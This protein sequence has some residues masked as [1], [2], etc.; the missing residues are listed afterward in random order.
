MAVTEAVAKNTGNVATL[1]DRAKILIM[2]SVVLGLFLEA[3]DQTIVAT[4]LPAIV[5][6]FQGID[7]LAWVSTGYL[8][9]S[10]ALVPIYGKLSDVLGRR[11]IILFG[12]G[13]FLLGSILCGVA[14]SMLQLVIFRC[15]QGAGAAA[16]TSTAF[17]IPADLYPPSERAKATGL[18]GAAFGIASILGPFIGGF[19]TDAISWRWIFFV[20]I[21]FA[22]LA[23]GAIVWQMPRLGSERREPIDWLG[24]GLLLLTVIPLLLALSLDKARYGWGSPLIIG[25]LALGVVS[26]AAL[27][28]AERRAQSPIVD[29]ALFRNRTFAIVAALSVVNG[30]AILPTVLFLP[31]F[32]VNVAGVSATAAGTALIPQTLAIVAAAIISGNIVQRLGRYKPVMLV[33]F[34]VSSVAYIFLAT[35]SADTST[36]GVIWRVVILGLGL[37]CVV[38]LFSLIAQNALPHRYTG[39][40]SATVQFCQQMG[41][42]LGTVIFGAVLSALLS[43][44]FATRVEPLVQALPAA[45]QQ[46]IDLDRLRNGSVGGEG[47]AA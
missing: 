18:I 34:A 38:P 13:V 47:G 43:S 46:Q 8:L 29:G 24:T 7:L 44:Q 10:T 12:I 5:V 25:L 32:L 30:L 9:A 37:G 39:S 15:L 3:L 45:Q 36:F 41:G 4:A 35:M 19:L 23:A 33:G 28:W 6:E 26:L 27:V 20:N 42:V 2:A 11:A 1:S 22:L 31:L 14:G 21:P 40:A 16:I 17:A